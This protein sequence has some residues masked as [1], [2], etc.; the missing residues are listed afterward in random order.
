MR[1]KA[2]TISVAAVFAARLFVALTL[3]VGAGSL[4]VFTFFLYLGPFY[5][6]QLN[7][8][9]V[10]A[11]LFDAGLCFVFF[12]QHSG[13]VR[14]TVRIRLSCVISEH[15]TGAIYSIISGTVLLALVIFWQATSPVLASADGLSRGLMRTLFFLAIAVQAWGIWSLKAADLFGAEALLRNRSDIKPSTSLVIRGPYRWV[16]HPLY[17]T[18]L[19]MIWSYPDLTADRL[20]FN[21]LFTAWIYTGAVLE[22]RDLVEAYGDDYRQY[23]RSV[24][25][26]IPYQKSRPAP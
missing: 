9:L 11:L 2:P 10:E 1:T 13:M 22:E 24:P 5:L 23:Q 4:I 21:L 7:L 25:M 17:I 18:T 20:L 3:T 19:L 26:L 8:D 12:L 16:R 14:K 15:F 6:N